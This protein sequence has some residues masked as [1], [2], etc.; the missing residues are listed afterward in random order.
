MSLEEK[1]SLN[2]NSKYLNNKLKIII[3]ISY[4]HDTGKLTISDNNN[5]KYLCDLF[6]RVKTKF[7]PNVT[8]RASY[9]QRQ[10]YYFN[11]K[12]K[13]KKEIFNRPNTSKPIFLTK[14]GLIEYH[15]STKKF[16]GYSKFPRPLSPPFSNMPNCQMKE[17]IKKDLIQNLEKYYSE[18]NSKKLIL[19]S[20]HNLGLSYMTTDLNEFDFRKVDIKKILEL[21]RQTLDTI[22]EKY[23]LKINDFNKLPKVKALTQFMN[24]LLSN[25]DTTILNGKKLNKPNSQIKKKYD[26]IKSAIYRHRLKKNNKNKLTINNDKNNIDSFKKKFELR[27]LTAGT[28][29]KNNKKIKNNILD[30]ILKIKNNDLFLGRKINMDFGSF[31]YEKEQKGAKNNIAL[32]QGNK[33]TVIKNQL[34]EITKESEESYYKEDEKKN[35]EVISSISNKSESEKKYEKENIKELKG[36]NFML[37]NFI[38]EKNLIKGFQIEER[39]GFICL[40]KNIRP[41][42]KNNGELYEK[43]MELLQR[44]N[45]IAFKIQQKKDEFDMKQLIKKVNTQRINADNVMKGKKL[46]I[47]KRNDLDE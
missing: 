41:K 3:N 16:E 6:G 15:P 2:N 42:Y 34:T 46:K 9:T 45:P 27:N 26:C 38:K 39:K 11:N 5:N 23:P 47:Q 18:K 4:D 13:Q 29:E 19:N 10:N 14:K 24:Y 28:F 43:D 35:E 7:L 22:K 36:L 21:I 25:K 37:N 33:I 1:N 8:G 32:A 17:Q 40:F 30:N 31:S 20:N 44:T 12:K